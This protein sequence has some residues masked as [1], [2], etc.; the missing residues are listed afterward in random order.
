[1]HDLDL[2]DVMS[3][4]FLDN[5]DNLENEVP[6]K[7]TKVALLEW[8]N[9]DE[10]HISHKAWEALLALVEDKQKNIEQQL[11]VDNKPAKKLY[12]IKKVEVATIVDVTPQALFG[13][14][15]FSNG[16]TDS[17]D[18]ANREL[19]KLWDARQENLKVSPKNTGNR[20]KKKIVL[21]ANVQQLTDAL[22]LH[23]CRTVKEVLEAAINQLPIDIQGKFK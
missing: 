14:L 15:A 16:L 19:Q 4:D 21:V 11:D 9:D 8:V 18:K 2:D 7:T 1:M 12:Q 17:F 3:D 22:E 10:E 23:R 13:S 20:S 6:S 5:L